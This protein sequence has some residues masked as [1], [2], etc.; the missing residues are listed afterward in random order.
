[1][2]D[3]LKGML[4]GKALGELAKNDRY[5]YDAEPHLRQEVAALEGDIKGWIKA[6]DSWVDVTHNVRAKL[7]AKDDTEA[8]LF[9]QLQ[10]VDEKLKEAHIQIPLADPKA[11]DKVAS[12]KYKELYLDEEVIALS[13]TDPKNKD[14]FTDKPI[15]PESEKQYIQQLIDSGEPINWRR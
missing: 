3:L 2:S 8:E 9:A 6:K 14:F 4:V 11:F 12:D 13:Y 15:L 10:E 7:I 5:V 1:M